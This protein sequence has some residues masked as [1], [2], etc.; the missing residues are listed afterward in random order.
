MLSSSEQQLNV[1]PTI[2]TT[3]IINYQIYYSYL[4][5][6]YPS[7]NAEQKQ[8]TQFNKK[9][10]NDHASSISLNQINQRSNT[11]RAEDNNYLILSSCKPLKFSFAS[12]WLV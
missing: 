3:N 10:Y 9:L 8:S 6:P 4:S 11:A 1:S 2:T 12:E 5:N 7:S